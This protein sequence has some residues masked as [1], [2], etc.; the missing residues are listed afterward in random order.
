MAATPSTRVI[1]IVLDGLRHTTARET[2]GWLEGQVRAGL[3]GCHRIE[4]ELPAISRPLYE[5]ILT[6]RS[7]AQHGIVSN[8]IRRASEGDSVFSR[9]R[10]AGGR[11]AAAAYHWISELYVST[12][13]D[14]ARDR[15]RLDDDGAITDGVFYWDDAYPDDHLF[16]DAQALIARGQPHFLL[17]HPMNVDDAGHKWGGSSR[18]YRDAARAQGDLLARYLPGWQAQGYDII[19]TADHGMSDDHSHAGPLPDEVEVPFYTL[20][21]TLDTAP[22]QTEIAG[23]CCRLAGVDPG[24]LPPYAGGINRP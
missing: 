18:P 16:A 17:L 8:H 15:L 3:A 14:P 1:L 23:L 10:A 13:F 9:V 7:P 5:T 22:L 6:G 12:P 20:G 2:L 21:F 4:A 11:T 19:V 24:A